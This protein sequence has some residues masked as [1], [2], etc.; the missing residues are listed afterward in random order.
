[1]TNINPCRYCK[2]TPTAGFYPGDFA[3]ECDNCRLD[4][5]RHMIDY[6]HEDFQVSATITK[7]AAITTW[8]F[9]NP[10]HFNPKGQDSG[11]QGQ[12]K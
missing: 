8:N 7:E 5:S 11:T 10:P 2:E 12:T 3:I 9:L 6:P 4:L 1:M